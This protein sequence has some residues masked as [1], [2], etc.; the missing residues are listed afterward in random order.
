MQ[1]TVQSLR[2]ICKECAGSAHQSYPHRTRGSPRPEL[3]LLCQ[4]SP[5]LAP[6]LL[7]GARLLFGFRAAVGTGRAS[8][9]I[10]EQLLGA[11]A[12]KGLCFPPPSAF[13][14]NS[15]MPKHVIITPKAAEGT[16]AG[17]ELV[18]LLRNSVPLLFDQD[19]VNDCCHKDSL[20]PARECSFHGRTFRLTPGIIATSGGNSL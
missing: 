14:R 3:A 5:Q 7:S 18:S 13:S 1:S 15:G 20:L 11:Q 9:S 17:R 4:A 19:P 2:G 8:A 12:T 6:A 10:R 16:R